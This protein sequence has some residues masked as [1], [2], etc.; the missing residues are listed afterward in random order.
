MEEVLVDEELV[1]GDEAVPIRIRTPIQPKDWP[2]IERPRTVPRRTSIPSAI[3]DSKEALTDLSLPCV[4]T[5]ST[6]ST[7]R[8]TSPE[9]FPLRDLDTPP[10]LAKSFRDL[11]LEVR[12]RIIDYISGEMHSVAVTSTYNLASSMRHPRR[13][14]VSDLALVSSDWRELVQE[15]IFRH[16]KI[17]GTRPGLSEAANFFSEHDHLAKYVRHIEVWVPVWGDRNTIDPSACL[18]DNG[19]GPPPPRNA[20]LELIADPRNIP[21]THDTQ[22]VFRRSLDS[23]TL[24]EIFYLIWFFFP[25]TCIFTL[26]G[27]HCKKSNMIK[28]FRGLRYDN[29]HLP[30]LPQI[31]TF[32]MRGA[33]NIM[34]S[35]ADWVL[36]QE[37]LP[38]LQEWHCNYAKPRQEAYS[39]ISEILPSFTS[40]QLRHVNISLDG[41]YS[42]D[43]NSM[44][45]GSNGLSQTTVFPPHVCEQLGQIAAQLESLSYTGKI[46]SCFWAATRDT[47][48]K[49]PHARKEPRLKS[50][51]I[52]VKSCCRQRVMSIDPETGETLMDELGGV[53]ADGAGI[54]NLV[55]IRAFERLVLAT[56]E[57]LDMFP[58]LEHVRIRFIDLDSPCAQ[59]N[60][61]WQL[62]GGKLYGLWS[63]E[64]LDALQR[65]WRGTVGRLDYHELGEGINI[66]GLRKEEVDPTAGPTVLGVIG[67]STGG[68]SAL[69][70]KTKP[71]AIKS[72]AYRIVAETRGS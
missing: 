40:G 46:C 7:Q 18:V 12:R 32:A 19:L 17:K 39:T 67:S 2:G 3:V 23:A 64:I 30:V 61:Y 9:I 13:K 59:L 25:S 62:C 26:E 60:P 52:V 22:I 14:A 57:N 55:F 45:L 21:A 51:E 50:L 53:M 72:S 29:S 63:E 34:R 36:I 28:Q 20:F 35:Y 49:S 41:M 6:F 16:I 70:P 38:N 15:R 10:R 24:Q 44:T 42:K 56:V 37:A 47:Q 1:Q 58:L 43:N 65:T 69:Y 71:K 4:G 8:T 66:V 48:R 5:E 33:W 54:T 11:P 31:R 27:G 68:G